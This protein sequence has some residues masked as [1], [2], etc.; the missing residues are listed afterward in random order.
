[1]RN[2]WGVG[3]FRK[4]LDIQ[5]QFWSLWDKQQKVVCLLLG[6]AQWGSLPPCAGSDP[7][8]AR[9]FA[10]GL[11]AGLRCPWISREWGANST[12]DSSVQLPPKLML[13]N[14][15]RIPV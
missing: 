2:F 7:G 9:G 10:V 12:C 6:T 1:M 3:V 14:S 8:Q 4:V 15:R 5:V 13:S 11:A